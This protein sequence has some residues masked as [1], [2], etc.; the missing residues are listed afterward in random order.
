M[1]VNASL[2]L[3]LSRC[4]SVTDVLWLLELTVT[5]YIYYSEQSVLYKQAELPRI[6]SLLLLNLEGTGATNQPTNQPTNQS[7]IN[8]CEFVAC[9]DCQSSRTSASDMRV[10]SSP[11]SQD[12]SELSTHSGGWLATGY[13]LAS[14]VVRVGYTIIACPTSTICMSITNT[15]MLCCIVLLNLRIATAATMV[16]WFSVTVLQLQPKSSN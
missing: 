2:S 5:L 15:H 1:Y 4:V 8:N 3:S 12:R 7:V 16:W 10:S 6:L 13:N 14:Y 9:N 11:S